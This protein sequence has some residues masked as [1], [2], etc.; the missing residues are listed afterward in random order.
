MTYSEQRDQMQAEIDATSTEFSVAWQELRDA[1]L[2]TVSPF[3][4][5]ILDRLAR[6]LSPRQAR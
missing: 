1:F 6:L 4:T 3:L 5:P 2:E